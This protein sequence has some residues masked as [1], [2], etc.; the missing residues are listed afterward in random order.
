MKVESSLDC[1]LKSSWSTTPSVCECSPRMKC[2]ICNTSELLILFDG[3]SQPRCFDFFSDLRHRVKKYQFNVGQCHSCGVI[4]LI[5]PIPGDQLQPELGWI[6]NNEPDDHA[7]KIARDVLQ[8]LPDNNSRVLLVS[9]FDKRV[10]NFI[11]PKI[12]E[13]AVILDPNAD[14]GIE[15]LTPNQAQIQSRI[16]R[17]SGVALS[18]KLGTFE[19]IVTCRMVE[20][21]IKPRTLIEG[22]T[23]LMSTGCRLIV[24][25][26]DS[27]KPLLQGD[28]AMLWEEHM[29]YFTPESLRLGFFSMGFVSE[30]TSG[31]YYPQEDALMTV[32]Q[33]VGKPYRLPTP[34]GELALGSLYKNKLIIL[35]TQI[36]KELK[37]LSSECGKI[38]IF[39]A[40]HRTVMFLN[41]LGLHQHI[42]S[43]VDDS[44]DKQGLIVPGGHLK[45][46]S[47]D[48]AAKRN[49][50][51]YILSVGINI[52]SKIIQSLTERATNSIVCKSISPDSRYALSA[53][54]LQ[55]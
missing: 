2:R 20:H 4:Q 54:H 52:E 37:K 38:A 7:E 28:V 41:L 10:Y 13:R 18:K 27:T 43:I 53:F 33:K 26:P 15:T 5:Y 17:D 39:G 35:K 22:L 3:G 25:I 31:F 8:Y 29:S 11:Q 34:W 42:S 16:T 48:E 55:Q 40:G 50:G 32:F 19:V 6:K 36:T 21:S 12:G 51:V 49:I 30:K 9:P 46:I 24:E 45:I 23:Q 47:S 14:L 44:K 1:F